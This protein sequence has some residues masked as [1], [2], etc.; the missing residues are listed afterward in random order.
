MN[1]VSATGNR[2]TLFVNS[3]AI[4]TANQ[5]PQER[6]QPLKLFLYDMQHKTILPFGW[7]ICHSSIL[8]TQDQAR[9][10]DSNSLRCRRNSVLCSSSQLEVEGHKYG[11]ASVAQL[12][13]L[14]KQFHFVTHTIHV[15]GIFAHIYHKINQMSVNIPYMDGMGDS[16]QIHISA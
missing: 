15:N 2:Y 8:A 7:S 6:N 5:H 1:D 16:K 9:E 13:S 3:G 14:L 10:L 4:L 12:Q 11:E